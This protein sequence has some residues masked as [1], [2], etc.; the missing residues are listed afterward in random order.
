MRYLYQKV[1]QYRI[2]RINRGRLRRLKGSLS[3]IVALITLTSM[4]LQVFSLDSS[5][6]SVMPGITPAY[7]DT[8]EAPENQKPILECHYEVHTHT[9]DCYRTQ[10]V[11]DADGRQTGTE[12]LLK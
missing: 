4:I 11:F 12:K 6:A 7:T 8:Q 1:R 5:T 10:P 2:N 9:E 3:G